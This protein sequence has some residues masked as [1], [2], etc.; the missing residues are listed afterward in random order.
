[1]YK[2][3]KKSFGLHIFFNLLRAR[4]HEETKPKIL[5][6]THPKYMSSPKNVVSLFLCQNCTVN[7]DC[8]INSHPRLF[9]RKT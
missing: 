7:H 5:F 1:M 4:I 8:W 6:M 2:L 3:F 9:G